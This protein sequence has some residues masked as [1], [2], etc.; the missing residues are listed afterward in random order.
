[1]LD[2]IEL[3]GSAEDL[4]ETLGRLAAVG[5]ALAQASYAV[6]ELCGADAPDLRVVEG[7]VVDGRH[8]RLRA[9][10]RTRG[11]L[12]GRIVVGRPEQAFLEEDRRLVERLAAV[13]G[14]LVVEAMTAED[15]DSTRERM[16]SAD[17]GRIARDLHDLVIQRLYATGLQLQAAK[18]G[19]HDARGSA[20]TAAV[21]D[22]DTAIRDVRATIFELSRGPA[23]SLAGE[24]RALVEEYAPALGFVPV[25]RLSGP[26]DT[27]LLDAVADEALLV[28]REALS[29]IARHAHASRAQVELTA[30]PAWFMLRVTDDGVGIPPRAG[31]ASGL[32]N[33]GRRAATRG[34][35][36]RTGTV[37]P[38]GTSLVWLVPASG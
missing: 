17:R 13:A 14:P 29:N 20:I 26:V 3:I 9:D 36:M 30:S 23:R 28:L 25:L 5:R 11:V 7:T 6:V 12:L 19:D 16:L 21:R 22:I 37:T 15:G 35:V 33:A 34:G 8:E 38:H 31:V 2:A 32:R 4:D 10:L 1:L 24:A 18:G 27:A